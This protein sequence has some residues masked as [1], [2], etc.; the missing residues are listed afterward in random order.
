MSAGR[1]HPVTI[2]SPVRR[3]WAWWLRIMWPAARAQ[4]RIGRRHGSSGL[5]KRLPVIHFAHWALVERLPPAAPGGATRPLRPPYVL[6]QSNFNGEVG[7]R[8]RSGGTAHASASTASAAS[9]TSGA[10]WLPR[11]RASSAQVTSIER[12]AR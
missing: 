1:A 11:W 10:N 4:Q 8:R 3:W 5:S 9:T 2:L 7:S 6:F 12:A